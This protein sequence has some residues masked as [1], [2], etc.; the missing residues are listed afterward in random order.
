VLVVWRSLAQRS[1][2]AL[3]CR[4]NRS[5]SARG[6][7]IHLLELGEVRLTSRVLQSRGNGTAAQVGEKSAVTQS[8]RVHCV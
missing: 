5:E 8:L 3:L 1:G 4:L 7:R 2:S 6:H